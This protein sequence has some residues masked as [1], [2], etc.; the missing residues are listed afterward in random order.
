MIIE[1][2]RPIGW[3]IVDDG[4]SRF[5][6]VSPLV[7]GSETKLV[8]AVSQMVR[9]GSPA[10]LVVDETGRLAGCLEFSAVQRAAAGAA[11]GVAGESRVEKEVA[12]AHGSV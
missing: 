9:A 5:L 8:D 6:P 10:A 11:A 12:S 3:L 4:D 1:N 7:L 2:G